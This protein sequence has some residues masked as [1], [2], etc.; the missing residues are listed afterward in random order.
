MEMLKYLFEDLRL[1]I[2]GDGPDHER[3]ETFAPAIKAGDSLRFLGI[4]PDLS[5]LYAGAAAVWIPT[6]A[7]RGVQVALEA[8]QAGRPV[9]AARMPRLAEIVV[10]GETGFLVPAGDK[11]LLAKQTRKLFDDPQLAERMGQA[12]RRR[13]LEK[14]SQAAFQTRLLE[15]IRA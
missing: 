2:V 15:L 13:L 3:L 12:G 14:F 9:V 4:Q 11:V 6:H 8:M 5:G 10:D 1:L 7:D